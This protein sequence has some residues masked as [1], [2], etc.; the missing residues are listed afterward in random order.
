MGKL[1]EMPKVVF[2]PSKEQFRE[3]L[4]A[5]H[6]AI[7]PKTRP[8]NSNALAKRLGLPQRTIY[9]VLNGETDPYESLDQI[10]AALRLHPWQLLYP[11]GDKSMLRLLRA[12][13]EA[14]DEG[15]RIIEIAVK[16]VEAEIAE[17]KPQREGTSATPE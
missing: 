10:A 5:L 15:R 9:G 1:Y 14:S 16:G 13:N 3:N 17:N 6:A 2:K 12:Y 11:I 8:D 4:L 7:D